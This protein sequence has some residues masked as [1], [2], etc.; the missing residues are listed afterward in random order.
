MPA[1]GAQGGD[2]VDIGRAEDARLRGGRGLSNSR[3]GGPDSGGGCGLRLSGGCGLRLSGS[4]ALGLS[5]CRVL[6]LPGGG[7]CCGLSGLLLLQVHAIHKDG[8]QDK[9]DQSASE[10]L[11]GAFGPHPRPFCPH[12]LPSPRG[13]GK[14]SPLA[15]L[16]QGEGK[17]GAA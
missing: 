7:S 3:L 12:P 14:T 10:P 2:L 17:Y 1:Q 16:P 5:G 15:P 13:E 11:P 4:C 9:N 6:F 8:E